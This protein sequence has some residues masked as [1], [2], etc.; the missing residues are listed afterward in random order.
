MWPTTHPRDMKV[1]AGKDVA[2]EKVSHSEVRMKTANSTADR[3]P[4]EVEYSMGYRS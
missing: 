3:G 4:R 1:L 2:R